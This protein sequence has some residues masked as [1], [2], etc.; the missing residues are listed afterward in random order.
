M[1]E[2]GGVGRGKGDGEHGVLCG[3]DIAEEDFLH[4]F[5]FYAGDS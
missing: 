3:N 1:G 5:S 2:I 4:F